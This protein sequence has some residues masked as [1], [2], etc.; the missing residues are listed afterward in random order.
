MDIEKEAK[1]K[2]KAATP[3]DLSFDMEGLT[4][5]F[6]IAMTKMMTMAM[7]MIGMVMIGMVM[8]LTSRRH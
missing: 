4:A 7:V 6:A 1:K 2:I 5:P 3:L 8:V